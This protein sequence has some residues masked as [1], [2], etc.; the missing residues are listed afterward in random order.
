MKS[1][2]R[3][4]DT[5]AA[6]SESAQKWRFSSFSFWFG[7]GRCKFPVW[8]TARWSPGKNFPEIFLEI[9]LE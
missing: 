4:R 9:F 8:K 6:A 7:V 5:L 2:N 1:K 3:L